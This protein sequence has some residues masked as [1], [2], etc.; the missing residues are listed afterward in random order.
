MR[1][2]CVKSAISCTLYA[3]QG[4]FRSPSTASCP[5]FPSLCT[6]SALLPNL[7]C[8]LHAVSLPPART[9]PPGAG[10]KGLLTHHC[11]SRAPA[12]ACLTHTPEPSPLLSAPATPHAKVAQLP[13]AQP[14]SQIPDQGKTRA[15]LRGK[16]PSSRDT[17][18]SPPRP[19]TAAARD[20]AQISF[21]QNTP[22]LRYLRRSLISGRWV[23]KLAFFVT[24]DASAHRGG[25][26]FL[27]YWMMVLN[28]TSVALLTICKALSHTG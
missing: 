20:L 10:R 17:S 4:A 21:H 11:C 3:I 6:E 1:L 19:R 26:S 5:P 27:T 12:P 24:L 25:P 9:P 2:P 23:L 18:C 14:P 22:G 7:G 15:S 13:P 8:R 28:Y 16:T